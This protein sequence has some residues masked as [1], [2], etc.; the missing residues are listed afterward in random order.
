M[1]RAFLLV[2]LFGALLGLLAQE[3]AFAAG[4]GMVEVKSAV[5]MPTDCM[6]RMQGEQ[7]EPA[8]K[9]CTGLT[10][11]CIATMGCVIPLSAP[12]GPASPEA[13]TYLKATTHFTLPVSPLPGLSSQPEPEPPNFLI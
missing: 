2:L 7:P 6:E 11:D 10:L 5:A 12:S 13:V 1:N 3:A 9:P 8:Q 4:P